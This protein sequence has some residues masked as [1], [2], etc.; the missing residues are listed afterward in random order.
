MP[1]YAEG[2]L[3]RNERHPP[4]PESHQ[5]APIPFF[6]VYAMAEMRLVALRLVWKVVL[7]NL[8]ADRPISPDLILEVSSR[9]ASGRPWGIWNYACC[10]SEV[11]R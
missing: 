10:I 1:R 3:S 7:A 2:H 5:L 11:S 4:S 6:K 9:G 8:R